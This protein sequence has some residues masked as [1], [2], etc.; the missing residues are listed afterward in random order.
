MLFQWQQSDNYRQGCRATMSFQAIARN[1]ALGDPAKEL[2]SGFRA[3]FSFWR[4]N[5]EGQIHC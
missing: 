4:E 5:C 3:Y 1:V 2:T